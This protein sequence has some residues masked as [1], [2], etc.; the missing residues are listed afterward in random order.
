MLPEKRFVEGLSQDGSA[1]GMAPR[2]GGG[3]TL[4]TWGGTGGFTRWLP[5]GKAGGGPGLSETEAF[6]PELLG[7]A[8][9]ICSLIES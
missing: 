3:V 9:A 2:L 7:L 6:R 5:C 8:A 4:R 1:G